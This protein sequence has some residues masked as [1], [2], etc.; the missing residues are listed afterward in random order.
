MI[1]WATHAHTDI[2]QLR[3]ILQSSYKQLQSYETALV[4]VQNDSLQAMDG[5][6]CVLLVLLDLSADFDMVDHVKVLQILFLRTLD[7]KEQL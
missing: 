7:L 4:R 6:K 3:E 5:R 2:N 1:D